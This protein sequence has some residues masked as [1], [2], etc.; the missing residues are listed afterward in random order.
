[1][2]IVF[3]RQLAPAMG[4]PGSREIGREDSRLEIAVVFTSVESTLASLRHAG[5]LAHRLA[6]RII[7]LVPQIV[8]YPLPL[9]SPPVL[10]DWN[11]RRFQAIAGASPVDTTVRLCLCRD[12]EE[13]LGTALGRRSLVVLAGPRRWWRF[14]AERRLARYLKRSG[15]ELVFI[16]T[17]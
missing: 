14:T 4:R 17:E 3:E 12:R 6:G 8:P 11:E 2:A 13:M 10:I 15:H 16:E 7:L 1:M 9:A 5:A